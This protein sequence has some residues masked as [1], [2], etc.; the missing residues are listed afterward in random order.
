MPISVTVRHAKIAKAL[1]DYAEAKAK[2]VVDSFHG[3]ERLNV[4][5]DKQRHNYIAEVVLHAKRRFRAE[6][7]DATDNMR[8]SIDQAFEKIEKQM[9]K[10]LQKRHDHRI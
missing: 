7:A 2:A 3:V 5:L 10:R 1:K 8:K 6:A 9:R 4:V